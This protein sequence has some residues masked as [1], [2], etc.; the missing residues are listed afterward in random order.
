MLKW[1]IAI[2]LFVCGIAIDEERALAIFWCTA[3]II[4]VFA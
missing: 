3:A 4:I 2:I 1:V